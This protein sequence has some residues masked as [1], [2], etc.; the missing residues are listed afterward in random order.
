MGLSNSRDHM[1]SLVTIVS[2]LYSL[3]T[4]VHARHQKEFMVLLVIMALFKFFDINLT[5]QML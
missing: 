3:L 4:H 1:W 5:V 2:F